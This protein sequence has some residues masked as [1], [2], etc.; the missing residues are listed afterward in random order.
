MPGAIDV[1]VVVDA[2]TI[3]ATY[4]SP[5]IDPDAP[6]ALSEDCCYLIAPA[7]NTRRGLATAH[8]HLEVEDSLRLEWR[9]LSLSGAADASAVIYTLHET[10]GGPV[11]QSGR[12]R[13]LEQWIPVPILVGG[14]NQDPPA[15]SA[16]AQMAYFLRTL[17]VGRRKDVFDVCF[18]ITQPDDY[19]RPVLAGYFRW[20][21]ALTFH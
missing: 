12:P 4:S 10:S 20:S 2:E 18:Y 14:V 13:E 17:A 8:L 15:F 21:A 1:V 7:A 9:S 16:V 3:L 5:S 19:G 11:A 6:T